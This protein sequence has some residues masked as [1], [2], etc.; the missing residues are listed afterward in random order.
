[1]TWTFFL[2][3]VHLY[4]YSHRAPEVFYCF[5][6]RTRSLS[7]Q[8]Q[9]AWLPKHSEVSI[10]VLACWLDWKHK[11]A[12]RNTTLKHFDSG[13]TASAVFRE[14]KVL[15]PQEAPKLS[16]TVRMLLI[17][18]LHLTVCGLDIFEG[19]KIYHLLFY[20]FS[21]S[22][23]CL[24]RDWMSFFTLQIRRVGGVKKTK[25]VLQLSLLR[26]FSVYIKTLSHVWSGS[27]WGHYTV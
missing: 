5:S 3:S 19:K 15:V 7:L 12:Q 20:V 11:S 25:Q 2:V 6:A 10:D 22:T 14:L 23:I 13:F 26:S 24:H 21:S 17:Q 1:M 4:L 27:A 16:S 9:S 8:L 18:N